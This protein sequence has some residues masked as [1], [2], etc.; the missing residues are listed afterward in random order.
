MEF[1][2]QCA[3]KAD[4]DELGIQPDQRLAAGSERNPACEEVT[5]RA[6]PGERSHSP[7]A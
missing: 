6:K 1:R 7:T 2:G 5:N 4:I 3:K